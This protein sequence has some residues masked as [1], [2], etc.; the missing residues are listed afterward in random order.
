MIFDFHHDVIAQVT[1]LD[2][3]TLSIPEDSHIVL[4]VQTHTANVALVETG[5]ENLQDV[6]AIITLTHGLAIG[7]RTADCQPVLIYAP[8]I[9]AVAAIHAGWRGTLAG[10]TSKTISTLTRLGASPEYMRAWLGPSVC[11]GCYEVSPDLVE[12]FVEAGFKSINS[13]DHLDLAAINAEQLHFAGI[14]DILFSGH[15]TRHTMKNDHHLYPSWRRE[16]GTPLRL[17]SAI[18]IR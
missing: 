4:P 13:P 18:M 11:G 7:V 12:R 3:D 16:P 14:S 5:K 10:I 9:R 15:C 1:T 17:I 8:D 2:D 6:D